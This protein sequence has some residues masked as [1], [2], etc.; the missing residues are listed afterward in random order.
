MDS[1]IYLVFV[2]GVLCF[3]GLPLNFDIVLRIVYDKCLRRKPRYIFQLSATF[4]SIFILLVDII[5]ISN[6]I[7]APDSHRLLYQFFMAIHGLPYVALLFNLLLSL[8]DSF[9]S[10]TFP[11]THLRKVT[12]RPVIIALAI[13]NLL[14]IFGVKWVFISG[15]LPLICAIQDRHFQTLEVIGIVLFVLCLI[16]LVVDYIQTLKLLPGASRALPQQQ[17]QE[18]IELDAQDDDERHLSVSTLRRWE[19]EATQLFLVGLFPLLLLPLALLVFILYNYIA[20]SWSSAATD[21]CHD[22]NWLIPYTGVTI[23]SIHA[24]VN[25]IV[26][27]CFNKD[28]TSPS[29]LRILLNDKYNRR[30]NLSVL[31]SQFA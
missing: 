4:S 30:R 20:C 22:F 10:V 27:R 3:F 7:F 21:L 5:Q 17:Q 31:S 23:M 28:F 9:F 15:E 18:E 16:F 2:L 19:L 8:I 11:L 26:S 14:L 13:L 24:I 12:V 29:P 6:F 25:P 1:N